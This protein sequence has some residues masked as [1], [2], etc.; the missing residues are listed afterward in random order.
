MANIRSSDERSNGVVE[1]EAAFCAGSRLNCIS[2][3]LL[4]H[5]KLGT[6]DHRQ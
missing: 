2:A 6:D 1:S 4:P 5:P 3:P